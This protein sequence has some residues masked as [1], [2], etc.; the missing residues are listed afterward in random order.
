[1]V[2]SINIMQERITRSRLVREPAYVLMRPRLGKMALMDFHR[3]APAIAEGRRATEQAMVQ[4]IHVLG[5]GDPR[6]EA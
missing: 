4:L 3:A 1:M 5:G 6:I 2:T